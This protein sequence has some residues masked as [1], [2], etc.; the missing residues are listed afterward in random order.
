MLHQDQFSYS[1]HAVHG[2][3]IINDNPSTVE[4]H[5][6]LL[7]AP[8]LLPQDSEATFIER[9]CKDVKSI[10]EALDVYRQRLH[11]NVEAMRELYHCLQKMAEKPSIRISQGLPIPGHDVFQTFTEL[12]SSGDGE[13]SAFQYHAP[14]SV[15]TDTLCPADALHALEAPMYSSATAHVQHQTWASTSSHSAETTLLHGG[16]ETL[17]WQGVMSDYEKRTAPFP[18]AYASYSQLATSEYGRASE[19]GLESS[20]C[21]SQQPMKKGHAQPSIAASFGEENSGS[22]VYPFTAGGIKRYRCGCGFKSASKG[23]MDRHRDSLR[24]SEPKHRC[25][26]GKFFTRVDSLKRHKKKKRCN[27]VERC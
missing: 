26:C 5:A 25:S 19:I 4:R 21:L 12:G 11:V 16:R 24:H 14:C 6:S 7:N 1:A 9:H 20:L 15:N 10:I 17:S 13:L 3:A 22:P 23:G 2:D 18:L 8:P 27:T